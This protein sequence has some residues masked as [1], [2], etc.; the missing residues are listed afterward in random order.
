[1]LTGEV[2]KPDLGKSPLIVF[3]LKVGSGTHNFLFGWFLL[4]YFSVKAAGQIFVFGLLNDICT[5]ELWCLGLCIIPLLHGPWPAAT[6]PN[7]PAWGIAWGS[8]CALETIGQL[9]EWGREFS[10]SAV[11]CATLWKMGRDP[12]LPPCTGISIMLRHLGLV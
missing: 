12:F 6:L 10:C 9:L 2:I 5:S 7:L 3:F 11:S 1:M 8:A 4:L